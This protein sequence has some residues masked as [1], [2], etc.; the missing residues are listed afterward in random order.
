VSRLAV[1]LGHWSAPPDVAARGA[2]LVAA[3]LM[4]LAL[5]P[6]QRARGLLTDHSRVLVIT[7]SA[8]L[9]GF[10]SLGYVVLYLHGGPRII[11]ATT[12]F[13]QGRALSH[14]AF[15][16]PLSDP[17]EAVRGRFLY[18]HDGRIGGI[19]PPGYPLLLAIGFRLGAPMVVGP[20]TAIALVL[21]TYALGRS[22]ARNLDEREAIARTAALLSVVCAALRYHTADTMA[23]GVSALEIA[24]ALLAASE[25]ARWLSSR[26]PE[27]VRTGRLLFLGAGLVLGLL[28]ATRPVS[29]IGAGV[30]VVAL[31]AFCRGSGARARLG[32]VAVVVVGLVPGLGLLLLSQHAVTGHWLAST[33]RA[34]Y[35]TSDG[36]PG[37]FRYGFG[38]GIGCLEEHGDFVRDRLPHGYTLLA[39]LLT[40]LRRLHLHL[41]DVLNFEPLALLVVVPFLP[42]GAARAQRTGPIRAAGLL[43]VVHVLAY[44]PFYFDGDYPGGGAR[45][46]ADLLPVEHVLAAT[47]LALLVVR[48]R[49]SLRHA[50]PRF[51]LA[52]VALSLFAFGVHTVNDHRELAARDGGSPMYETHLVQGANG[53]DHGLVYFDTDHGFDL[54]YDPR[55]DP[56]VK[57]ANTED[58]ALAPKD[59]DAPAPISLRAVRHRND[60]GDRLVYDRA[61]KP[62]SFRYVFDPQAAPA[63]P[64]VEA[65]TPTRIGPRDSWRFEAES[66]WPP[67]EQHDA[68][69]E[70][71]WIDGLSNGRALVATGPDEGTGEIVTTLP[72]PGSDAVWTF[73]PRIVM[74]GIRGHAELI[75]GTAPDQVTW[76]WDDVAPTML[77]PRELA[78]QNVATH[79]QAT[80]P[81]HLRVSGQVAWDRTMVRAR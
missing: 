17:S 52:V 38:A 19:F 39:A 62:A 35:A 12:Y 6:G 73:T 69:A 68:W 49:P 74:R 13:L 54:A 31:A 47:G 9:A 53:A 37:C 63:E 77:G 65:W 34:Y 20:F 61:G 22:L 5:L 33:Q 51:A 71:V 29:A 70:P 56:A 41:R 78:T 14:G 28:G 2:V 24:V 50:Y 23:H 43:L 45:F 48:A 55:Q 26:A 16:W 79:G 58:E 81:V 32:T 18:A 1:L 15:A 8:F 60:D 11:D 42:F 80:V 27:D 64:K 72:V 30:A 40:T 75:I 3:L 46:F 36:P 44:A 21:V 10:L 66:S 4:A 59:P 25:G 67:L 76:T 57:K 7:I